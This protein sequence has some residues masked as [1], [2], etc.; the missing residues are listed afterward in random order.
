[1]TVPPSLTGLT[2]NQLNRWATKAFHCLNLSKSTLPWSPPYLP[3]ENSTIDCGT[4]IGSRAPPVAK[5]R[6][7][8]LPA[9]LQSL[10]SSLLP[11][12]FPELHS[13]PF[14]SH[15]QVEK[16]HGRGLLG[17]STQPHTISQRTVYV[18]P[19]VSSLDTFSDVIG[20]Y[21]WSNGIHLRT[22][23]SFSPLMV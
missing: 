6:V 2:R 5:A 1:M 4:V 23:P 14:F 17:D 3:L 15:R 11:V 9:P 10:P 19:P 13:L 22:S 20:L 7:G 16:S 18:A 21:W 12:L 8:I